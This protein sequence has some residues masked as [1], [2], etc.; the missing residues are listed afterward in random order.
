MKPPKAVRVGPHTYSV[1]LAPELSNAGASGLCGTDTQEVHIDAKLGP[2]VERETVLHELIHAIWAQTFL[3]RGYPDDSGGGTGET[4]ID[5][6]APRL[7][8]L[9][10]DNP[11]LVTYLTS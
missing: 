7:L 9:L 10:R 6:L 1:T 5:E 11:R 3:K 8:A 2:T 4:I